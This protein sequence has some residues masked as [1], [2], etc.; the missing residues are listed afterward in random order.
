MI[1]GGATRLSTGVRDAALPET[2]N[3]VSQ[4]TDPSGR[5]RTS[6][7]T[8]PSKP[9]AYSWYRA[10]RA[11]FLPLI[12]DGGPLSTATN[13]RYQSH[14]RLKLHPEL[15]RPFIADSPNPLYDRFPI[16]D[17][18]D[19]GNVPTHH[20]RTKGGGLVHPAPERFALI[21]AEVERRL[22]ESLDRFIDASFANTGSV[23][24]P[25]PPLFW[26]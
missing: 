13:P 9:L 6:A 16:D 26:T 12:A 17:V 8:R 15:L 25:R 20:V 21:K 10:C 19:D 1:V 23:R 24:M 14:L 5:P 22:H 2:D 4:T 3:S 11:F 7:R 18:E